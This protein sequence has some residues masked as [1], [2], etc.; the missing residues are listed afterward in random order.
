MTFDIST[1]FLERS[2]YYLGVEYPAKLRHAL[3]ALPSDRLWWRPN[4]HAN[5]A[6]NLVLHLTGNVRQWIVS[7]VGGAADTRNRDEEFAAREGANA[8]ELLETLEKTLSEVDAVLATL[9]PKSLG[10]S[11]D[12]QGRRTTVFA[13]VYHVVEHFSTHTGQVILLAKIFAPGAISFYEDAGGL[14]RPTFL[15]DARSDV[16]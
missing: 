9:T 14:A 13:A 8:P 6:G 3:L 4:E 10:E 15:G 16:D 2:R 12:I 7:G 1:R 5:S 11:R